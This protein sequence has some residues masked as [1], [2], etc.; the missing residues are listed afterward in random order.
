M[1][2][3]AATFRAFLATIVLTEEEHLFKNGSITIDDSIF[4]VLNGSFVLSG[5]YAAVVSEVRGSSL[6]F[7]KGSRVWLAN[8][9]LHVLFG[10]V[11][12]VLES[13]IVGNS[14]II[15]LSGPN[16]ALSVAKSTWFCGSLAG[17]ICGTLLVENTAELTIEDSVTEF[18]GAD[19]SVFSGAALRFI[20]AVAHISGNLYV[21]DELSSCAAWRSSVVSVHQVRPICDLR[22]SDLIHTLRTYSLDPKQNFRAQAQLFLLVDRWL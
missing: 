6:Q 21:F 13:H 17:V 4:S 22:P 8:S 15:T 12:D 16:A 9:E 11:V 14:T 10:C 18:Y 2:F 19:F 1:H 3:E 5:V 20:S 7:A